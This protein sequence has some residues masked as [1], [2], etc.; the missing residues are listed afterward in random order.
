MKPAAQTLASELAA[1]RGELAR[2]DSKCATLA[3]LTG[4]AAVYAA[5]QAGRG[6]V[7][8]RAA[9]ALAGL[10][11]GASVLVLLLTVL[12]PRL[13]TSG[14]CRWARLSADEIRGGWRDAA[15]GVTGQRTAHAADAQD[16]ETLRALSVIAVTKYR[17]LRLAVDLAAAGV[18]LLGA[19]AVAGAAS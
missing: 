6:P 15:E 5:G 7:A 13:G 4:A 16:A 18:V 3:A 17:R 19:A 14:F 8:A 11:F 1:V 12:R 10:V 2:I 9:T